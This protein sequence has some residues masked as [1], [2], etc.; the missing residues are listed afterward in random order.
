MGGND[1]VRHLNEQAANAADRTG[2]IVLDQAH[3]LENIDEDDRLR[4]VVQVGYEIGF[5]HWSPNDL[6]DM[7][8]MVVV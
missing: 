7:T 3:R 2:L 6:P 5:A 4:A 8:V 1:G